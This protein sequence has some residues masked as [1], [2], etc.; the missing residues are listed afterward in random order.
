MRRV[1]SWVSVVLLGIAFAGTA[2]STAR[3]EHTEVPRFH[4]LHLNSMYPERAIAFYTSQFAITSSHGRE[5][6]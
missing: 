4:H 2:P 6:M 1:S 3:F 5:T